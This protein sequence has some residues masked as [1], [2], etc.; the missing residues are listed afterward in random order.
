MITISH[1]VAMYVN[2]TPVII[3]QDQGQVAKVHLHNSHTN[4]RLQNMHILFL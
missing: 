1:T 4:L 2:Y 3:H